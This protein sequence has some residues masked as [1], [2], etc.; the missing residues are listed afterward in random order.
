MGTK[1]AFC[2][3]AHSQS[4]TPSFFGAARRTRR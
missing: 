3:Q 2:G 4:T 1:K